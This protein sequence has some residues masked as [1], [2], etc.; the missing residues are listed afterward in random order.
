MRRLAAVFLLTVCVQ[1]PGPVQ[2]QLFEL[3]NLERLNRRLCGRVVD[4]TRNH[5]A[6]RRPYSPILGRPRDLYVYLPP[7]YDP[8]VAYPLIVFLH[9]AD[10]DEHHFLDPSDLKLID[11]MMSRGEIPPA[12]IAAPDGTYEGKNR[13][14]ATHSLWVNGRGGRFQDHVVAEVVPFVERTYPIL[15]GRRA[16]AL[17]GVSAGGFGAMGMALKHRDVFGAVATLAGPINML[18]D[19]HAGRY[20]DDFDPATCRERT[21]YDPD[22]II[23]RFYFG[24]FRRRVRTFLE[25][26]YGAVHGL[27]GRIAL[28][29]PADLLK[30][31]DL[32]PGE[33]AIY[34][35]YP[36]RVNYNFD[37]QAESFIWLAA[38]RGVAVDTVC[39][40]GGHHN[41]KYIE[42]AEPAAYR[43]L[44]RHLP[45]PAA[46]LRSGR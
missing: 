16:H 2:A 25:P 33:L 19:N 35:N 1:A 30:T 3:V 11:Q 6:D 41:L 28:V 39:V 23:A 9:G 29:N 38:Q 5:G 18:Y 7:G 22:L 44:G 45:L 37:A 20:G 31:T 17:L 24:L 4:Y 32:R 36:E 43:W 15:P 8:S 46:S 42:T 12:V 10:L 26:V 27:V 14:T 40:P 13:L 21:E 34:D